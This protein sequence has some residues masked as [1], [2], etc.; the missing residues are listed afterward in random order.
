MLLGQVASTI[1]PD[2]FST[3]LTKQRLISGYQ[4]IEPGL[5]KFREFDDRRWLSI[6]PCGKQA[7]SPA[8]TASILRIRSRGTT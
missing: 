8:S 7:S 3:T 2:L 1:G 4:S 6:R 5:F